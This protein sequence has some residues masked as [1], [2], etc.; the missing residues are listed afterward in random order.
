MSVYFLQLHDDRSGPV[1]IGYTA[2]DVPTRISSL[3]TGS[4]ARLRWLLTIR[5]A[6][7]RVEKALQW[8]DVADSGRIA[9]PIAKVEIDGELHVLRRV[10]HDDGNVV[11][12]Y[13]RL[14]DVL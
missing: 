11:L 8:F 6:P 7:K 12:T 1:K 14:Q 5:D 2:G 10:E 4:P 9:A 13:D 3:Q